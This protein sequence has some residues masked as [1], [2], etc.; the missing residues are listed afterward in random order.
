MALVLPLPS[1]FL[2]VPLPLLMTLTSQPFSHEKPLPARLSPG[3]Y[4]GN[5]KQ[6]LGNSIK[7][8]EG[9][10]LKVSFSKMYKCTINCSNWTFA[11]STKQH[12]RESSFAF[13]P[14]PTRRTDGCLSLPCNLLSICAAAIAL[15][16]EKTWVE[17]GG[18]GSRSGGSRKIEDF[19]GG[20]CG[21]PG[22]SL[23][24]PRTILL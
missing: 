9:D 24:R 1:F 19:F 8:S 3:P 23:H 21:L 12:V 22:F 11:V 18:S 16:P 6:I 14:L 2:C 13:F 20:V 15:I 10:L 4:R 5:R 7:Y 17:N